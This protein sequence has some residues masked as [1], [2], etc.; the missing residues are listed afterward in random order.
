MAQ[1]QSHSIQP[2]ELEQHASEPGNELFIF[3]SDDGGFRGTDE[4]D[5]DLDAIYYFGIIDILTHWGWK[6]WAE[7]VWKGIKDDRV[8]LSLFR[9]LLGV[10]TMFRSSIKSVLSS[11]LNTPSGSK[12]S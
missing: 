7:G 2:A 10:L 5:A 6:K 3:Y 11:L 9:L 12:G 4:M 1:S 8:S